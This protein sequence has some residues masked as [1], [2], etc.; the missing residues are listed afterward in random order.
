MNALKAAI[1]ALTATCLSALLMNAQTPTPT[2]PATPIQHVIVIFDENNSFDHYF[3]TYPNALNPPGELQFTPL[4]NTPTVNGLTPSLIAN[5][6]NSTNRSGWTAR[7]RICAT[8]TTITP[9]SRTPTTAGCLT[10]FPR[11]QT[12]LSAQPAKT[13]ATTTETR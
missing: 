1:A 10:S 5:N 2:T 9:T 4:A 13:W 6:P 3:G 12:A 11:A 7:R 8:T